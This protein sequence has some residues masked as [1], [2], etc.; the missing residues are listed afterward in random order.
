M[1]KAGSSDEAFTVDGYCDEFSQSDFVQDLRDHLA[2]DDYDERI[3]GFL[4]AHAGEVARGSTGGPTANEDGDGEFTLAVTEVFQQYLRLV[5]THLEGFL[6]RHRISPEQ[7]KSRLERAQD[8]GGGLLVR[9]M[10][11][12]TEFASFVELCRDYV[13]DAAEAK[14]EEEDEDDGAK[15]K[16]DD[17]DDDDRAAKK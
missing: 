17:D 2:Q 8:S 13:E 14:D 10:L 12:S 9:M 4:T 5:E 7:F 11:A 3:E 6:E 16:D 1:A 15:A